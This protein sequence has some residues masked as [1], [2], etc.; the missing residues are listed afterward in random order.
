MWSKYIK[1]GVGLFAFSSKESAID[2]VKQVLADPKKHSKAATEIANEYFDSN[3]VLT[4]MLNKL[5]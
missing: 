5:S 4:E 3:K 1:S 2:C